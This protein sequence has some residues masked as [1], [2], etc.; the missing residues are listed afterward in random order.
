MLN[1]SQ[2]P[3]TPLNIGINRFHVPST[4]DLVQLMSSIV[5]E[6][7][8]HLLGAYNRQ[9]SYA[10]TKRR[11]ISFDVGTN[12]L[13][14]TSNIKLEMP[15]ARKLLPR[16]IGHFKVLKKVGK[17]VYILEL[18]ETLKVRDVFHISLLK[19]YKTSEVQPPPPP[20]LEDDE[21][22]FDVERVLIHEVRGSRMRPQKCYLIKWL[23][24]GLE[25]DS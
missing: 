5:Q 21:L 10:N 13:L 18:P 7:E 22:L 23:G 16:W 24:Y 8:K 6:V 4:K 12:V 17:I 14:S 3:L 19:S 15:G 11:E 20:I 9:K 1:F 2:Y 25:H